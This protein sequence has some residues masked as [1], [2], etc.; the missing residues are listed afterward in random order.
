[1]SLRT[2]PLL[3]VNMGGEMCYI[4][5]QRLQ[6]QSVKSDKSGKVLTDIVGTMFSKKFLDELFKT[7]V[8]VGDLWYLVF[9]FLPEHHWYFR[10]FQQALLDFD[11]PL[12]LSPITTTY[13]LVFN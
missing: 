4:L 2:M 12:R 5:D 6:A 9:S 7:Q 8:G 1:M 11:L 13:L 10:K 3:F